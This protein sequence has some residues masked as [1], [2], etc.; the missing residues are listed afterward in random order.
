[1]RVIVDSNTNS[2]LVPGDRRGGYLNAT[3]FA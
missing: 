2:V 1:M 3:V